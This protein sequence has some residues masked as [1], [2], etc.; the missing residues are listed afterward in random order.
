MAQN[1]LVYALVM[2]L[3]I[4]T[5]LFLFG[6]TGTANSSLFTFV[7]T[8]SAFTTGIFYVAIFAL[9]LVFTGSSIIPGSLWTVNTVGVFA[10]LSILVITFIVNIGHLGSFII[11]QTEGMSA[12][13]TTILMVFLVAPLAILYIVTVF[14]FARSNT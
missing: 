14:E 8:P 7:T 6:G 10:G 13:F 5:C 3:I 1:K 2:V 9:L 4:E 11:G 12:A